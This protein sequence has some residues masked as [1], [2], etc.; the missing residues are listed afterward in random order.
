MK[1]SSIVDD[2]L[3]L[4]MATTG[5][6]HKLTH[7]VKIDFK[8][9]ELDDARR[10]SYI[11]YINESIK[12]LHHFKTI[13]KNREFNEFVSSFEKTLTKD[14]KLQLHYEN[15]S[16]DIREKLHEEIITNKKRLEKENEHLEYR[17]FSKEFDIITLKNEY[18]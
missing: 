12:K 3:S 9:D 2:A 6:L 10:D 4:T 5:I 7:K 16:D 17:I 15:L 18:K 13:F 14:I 1:K 11:E 8:I